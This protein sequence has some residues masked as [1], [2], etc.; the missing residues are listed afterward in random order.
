MIMAAPF[1]AIMRVGALV[2]PEVMAG[3]TEAS[4]TPASAPGSAEGRLAMRQP[5]LPAPTTA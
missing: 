4:I 1:S 5:A 3:I 2:L